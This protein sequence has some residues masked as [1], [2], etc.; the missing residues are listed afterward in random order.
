MIHHDTDPTKDIF[1]SSNSR[2]HKPRLLGRPAQT[3]DDI[4]ALFYQQVTV[5]K[6]ADDFQE[7]YADEFVQT[8]NLFESEL[9]VKTSSME[10]SIDAKSFHEVQSFLDVKQNDEFIVAGRGSDEKAA[11]EELI[12]LIDRDD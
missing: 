6:S 9:E 5:Y 4:H 11:V 7:L 2:P 3:K 1:F 8:A 10:R 12:K